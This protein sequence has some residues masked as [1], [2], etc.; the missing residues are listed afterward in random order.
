M[1]S[2][3]HAVL[4]TKAA[5]EADASAW[6]ERRRDGG[7]LPWRYQRFRDLLE[8]GARVLDLGCGPGIDAGSLTDLGLEVTGLDL[9][10]SMLLVARGRGKVR[11][12]VEGDCRHLPFRGHLFDGVWA[13]ASLLHLPKAQVDAAL[14]EARRVLRDGGLICTFMKMG[15]WDGIMTQ[16]ERGGGGAVRGDRY[17][18]H[19]DP[20]EWLG[21]LRV[22][23]F[24]PQEQHTFD[25]QAQRPNTPWLTTFALARAS[26]DGATRLHA[27]IK[28]RVQGV[29]FRFFVERQANALGL[30]G[31]V[32]N[33]P[34]GSVEVLAEGEPAKLDRLLADVH[35]GPRHAAVDSV[36]A[37]WSR[38]EGRLRG[39]AVR[40]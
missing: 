30:S 3:D 18:A 16:E 33:L 7:F 17:F 25:A 21:H 6:A 13:S 36:D 35:R 4:V 40:A 23:G 8:P 29:G 32:R 22:A 37:A 9:T 14:R 15:D 27:A 38:A 24:E 12:L 39:F 34:D 26:P 31:W 28:G 5:Y 1:T 2:D 11:A 20:A 10:R 19:Y